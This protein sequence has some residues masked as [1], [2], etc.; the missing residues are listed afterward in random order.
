MRGRGWSLR[1]KLRECDDGGGS[2]GGGG[3]DDDDDDDGCDGGDADAS[4]VWCVTRDGARTSRTEATDILHG[5]K[6]K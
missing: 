1:G 4:C 3:G 5:N 2:G 6:T